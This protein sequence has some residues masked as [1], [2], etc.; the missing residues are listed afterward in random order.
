MSQ[1]PEVVRAW[2]NACATLLSPER[3]HWMDGSEAERTALEAS[4]VREG[5]LIPLNPVTHP[6]CFLHRSRPD[7]TARTEHLTFVCSRLKDDA[8][9]TNHWWAPDDAK[10]RL[11]EL[12]RDSM[13]GRTLY[14]VPFVLGPED[15]PFRKVGVQLTDSV[16]VALNLRIMTRV[17]EVAWRAFPAD[18]HFTRCLHGLGDQD[19]SR[20]FIVARFATSR[21][22]SRA[23][24]GRPTSPW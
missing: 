2:V 13:R 19:P 1:V 14:V 23:S 5:V 10:A 16:Y 8:G 3:V 11:T 21:R 4:A 7:D 9:P 22:R 18:G 17:G 20:R 15:S 24:A 6:R 12:F